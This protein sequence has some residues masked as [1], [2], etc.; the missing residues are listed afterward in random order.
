MHDFLEVAD[1]GQHGEHRLHQHAVLPLAALT[2]LEVRGIPFGGMKTGV[3]Q[4]NHVPIDLSNQPLKR[5]VRHIR[6]GTI[7]PHYQA[8]LVQ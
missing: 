7:P 2:Q 4:D 8:I 5:L 6:R 1:H 3:A